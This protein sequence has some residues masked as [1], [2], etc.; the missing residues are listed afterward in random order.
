MLKEPINKGKPLTSQYGQRT[1]KKKIFRE[2][3]NR[4]T[5]ILK[6]ASSLVAKEM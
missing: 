1:R 2:E 3:L 5:Q 4:S 6:C